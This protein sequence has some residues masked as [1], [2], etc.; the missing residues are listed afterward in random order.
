M[1][2]AIMFSCCCAPT[3]V[4]EIL[5]SDSNEELLKNF[6]GV[7]VILMM[8]FLVRVMIRRM[9]FLIDL[10]VLTDLTSVRDGTDVAYLIYVTNK[11]D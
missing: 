7:T 6:I 3:L 2:L 11:T 5:F 1:C 4:E 9:Y 8:R 10:I